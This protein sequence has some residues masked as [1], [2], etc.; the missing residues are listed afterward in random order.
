[1]GVIWIEVFVG[2]DGHLGEMGGVFERGVGAGVDDGVFDSEGGK[3]LEGCE[4]GGVAVG[5]EE[6]IGKAGEC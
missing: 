4:V 3:P 2:V 6:G 1:V 5:E